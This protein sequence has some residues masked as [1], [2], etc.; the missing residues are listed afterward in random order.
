MSRDRAAIIATRV[1]P[2]EVAAASFRMQLIAEALAT[3]A[4]VT[5]LTSRTPA[6]GDAGE[7]QDQTKIVVRR[8]PVLRDRSGAIRGYVQYLSFDIPLFFR[9]LVTRGDVIVAEA[10]PTTGLVALLA[11]FV[12][13]RRLVYYPGDIWTDAV[14]SMGAPTAV[15]A[16]IKWME[17]C[18]VRGADRVL[19]VSPEVAERLKDLGAAP[20]D[21]TVVGNGIDTRVFH[22]DVLPIPVARRYFVYTGT[23]S[24]WQ[25]PSI[26]VRAL[27]DLADT[28]VELR[29]FG[30]GA[31]EAELRSLAQELV[32]GRVHFGGVV[33][34]EESARWIRGAIGALVS[35][36]PG[37][38]YDFARPTKTYAAAAC[39]TPVLFAGASTGGAVVR[40]GGLGETADFA[41]SEVRDGMARLLS[42]YESGAT[43]SLRRQ[44]AEW[45][46]RNASLEAA[47][48]R[49]ADAVRT[50]VQGPGTSA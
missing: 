45:V 6:G 9:L 27:A 23:M 25:E 47:G 46:R 32:P 2:P 29:F 24:E 11:A 33:P 34:P 22:P 39:G 13:R 30:Q 12:R 50:L 7:K 49:A 28:E 17:S 26:F 37:I 1:Y 4:A 21:V 5:V 31:A 36:V 16:I 18:V 15:V 41:T 14:K 48:A 43:E 8:A 44:R 35:I 19:A 20:E 38:G 10:P 40:E 3:D 42:E